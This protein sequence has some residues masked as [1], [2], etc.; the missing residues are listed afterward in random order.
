MPETG[1]PAAPVHRP[2]LAVYA[3]WHPASAAGGRLAEVLFEEL[4]RGLGIPVFYRSVAAREDL[5]LPL[6]VPFDA[7]RHSAVFVLADRKMALARDQGWGEY[8]RDLLAATA[9]AQSP[10]R[11]VP[12]LLDEAAVKVQEGGLPPQGI[13]VNE[14]PEDL[15]DVYFL[16]R[17]AHELCRLLLAELDETG[18]APPAP[19]D[20]S[21]KPVKLF[22]SHSKADGLD[23][24]QDLKSYIESKSVF[25]LF[26]DANDI[27]PGYLFTEEIEA[28]LADP[29]AALL[30]LLTDSYATRP[31]CRKEVIIAKRFGRPVVIVHAVRRGESRCFPYLGNV[32]ALRIDR[33]EEPWTAADCERVLRQTLLEVLRQTYL[34]LHLRDLL[35][36]QQSLPPGAITL[37]RAPEL[38]TSLYEPVKTPEKE[39]GPRVGLYPDPPLGDEE[40]EVLGLLNSGI[41]W[42]TP[43]ML[44]LLRRP[45]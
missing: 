9:S 24:I 3:V 19:R 16:S 41:V 15:R 42:L 5:G 11:V 17:A 7:A 21:S 1:L 20:A 45:A 34:R 33:L 14:Q 23:R 31:W 22:L 28:N 29:R 37:P 36:E 2:T 40:L 26:F 18:G 12:V 6:P 43:A 10:H 39:T 25:D 35:A 30:V 4:F 44:P 38:L 27:A 8:V 13:R 32:P